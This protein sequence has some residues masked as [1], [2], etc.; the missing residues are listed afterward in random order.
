M[1]D[2]V[3]YFVGIYIVVDIRQTHWYTLIADEATNVNYGS[4]FVSWLDGWMDFIKFVK[5]Q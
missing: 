4:K 5:I 2:Y 3:F 1:G